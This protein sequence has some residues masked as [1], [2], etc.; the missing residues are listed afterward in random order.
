MT[1]PDAVNSCPKVWNY[2]NAAGAKGWELVSVVAVKVEDPTL[3]MLYL[4]REL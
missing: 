2:L 4:Q 1:T 3:Q